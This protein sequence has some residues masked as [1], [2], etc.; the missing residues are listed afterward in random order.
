MDAFTVLENTYYIVNKNIDFYKDNFGHTYY[1]NVHDE[2][3]HF[4]D[5]LFKRAEHKLTPSDK[6]LNYAVSSIYTSVIVLEE[7]LKRTN[8]KYTL[9]DIDDI[10]AGFSRI[11]DGTY[12]FSDKTFEELD[13]ILLG[14]LTDGIDLESRKKSGSERTPN[15]IV[16]YM[17]N[18]LGY[19]TSVSTKKSIIDPACGTGTFVKQIMERFIDGLEYNANLQQLLLEDKLVRA[20][21][22]KPSNVFV[23]K[24]V[25]ITSLLK[26][27]YISDIDFVK[28]LIKKLPIYCQDFLKVSDTADYIVGNPPYIRLQ[29]LTAEVRAYIKKNFRSST[30][31]FDIFTCFIERGDKLLKQN[32]RLCLITSNKYLTANYGVGIR[33]YLAETGHVRK[34]VDL[35]DTKF[36]GA[37]VLPA[38][39]LCEC[40]NARSPLIEY[41]GIKT[42]DKKSKQKCSDATE[43]FKYIEKIENSKE[44]VEYGDNIDCCTFEISKDHSKLPTDGKTWNFSSNNENQIKVKMEQEKLCCLQDMLDVCVGIKTT[45]DT[46][47]VKPMTEDFIKKNKFEDEVVFPLIQSF[48]VERW[49]INWGANNRDRYILYPHREEDGIMKA[50]QLE[51]IPNAAK[52][53]TDNSRVLKR[54]KYLAESK[55]RKWYEC[56]VPQK[57]SKFRQTKIITRDIVSANTFALDEEGYL[58]QGNTFF[59]TKKESLFVSKYAD[60]SEHEFYS[61][62]LGLLNST[63]LEYYQKLISGCLY[64]QKYR[65]TTTNLNKWPIPRIE[66]AEAKQIAMY[67]DSIMNRNME[68]QEAERKINDIVFNAFN[69]SDNEINEINKCIGK[70]KS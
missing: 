59:L 18:M 41:I 51:E 31:R 61:F 30:G 67:V 28:I 34:I 33:R 29:N 60:M 65:Y 5:K 40:S 8:I 53:L 52:Y 49:S 63:A 24:I 12:K 50:Y 45:A 16:T 47:F 23:T 44:Y 57:L 37:A 32:G 21:D 56:W 58:C 7:Y 6:M 4:I 11:D 10:C 55:T 25:I 22:T 15:E 69:L 19:D 27:G 14:L 3:T 36:F 20:Y 2:E 48:D 1:V 42:S 46:I 66:K 39:I 35:C 64:S 43:L 13:E 62:V 9:N 70:E 26:A 68:I 38:I 17:L 54:R